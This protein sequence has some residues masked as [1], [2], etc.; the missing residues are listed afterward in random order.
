MKEL[1]EIMLGL[2]VVCYIAA[3]GWYGMNKTLCYR[4][5]QGQYDAK[6]IA[7]MQLTSSECAKYN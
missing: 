7:A 4:M 6:E 2:A 1:C 5:A 3:C